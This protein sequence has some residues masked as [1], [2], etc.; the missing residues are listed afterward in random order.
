MIL[1]HLG[2]RLTRMGQSFTAALAATVSRELARRGMSGRELAKQ[3]FA[4]HGLQYQ[5][6]VVDRGAANPANCTF[7]ASTER[8]ARMIGRTPQVGIVDVCER[9]LA[10]LVRENEGDIA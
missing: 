9:I 3:I 2:L 1:S 7:A 5:N 6:H 10:A 8:L 4:R